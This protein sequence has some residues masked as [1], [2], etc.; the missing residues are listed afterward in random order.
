MRKYRF[1]IAL[2]IVSILSYSISN[3]YGAS[4][5][6][7]DNIRYIEEYASR[8]PAAYSDEDI[9]HVNSV[10]VIKDKTKLI[11]EDYNLNTGMIK[12]NIVDNKVFFLGMSFEDMIS[13]ISRYPEDFEDEGMD[14]RN[15]MLV[16]FA[17][18]KVVIRRSYVEEV[19]EKETENSP[20]EDYEYRYYI[21]DKDGYLVILKEDKTTIFLVT[22]ISVNALDESEI[23]KIKNGIGVKDIYD[24]YGYL[25]SL[26]S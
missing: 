17:Q 19:I 25:E 16:S 2:A 8:N 24:L 10:V 21:T 3:W 22:Q 13:Y 7:F 4:Y 15:I 23:I 9:G 20:I 5:M 14:V 26:T 11:F 1:F 18:S 12:E 6:T